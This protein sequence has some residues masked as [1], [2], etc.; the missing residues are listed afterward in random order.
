M[1][2]VA[3]GR[4]RVENAAI[5]VLVSVVAQEQSRRKFLWAFLVI[6]T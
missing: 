6:A 1:E 2:I 4:A 3:S 5:V